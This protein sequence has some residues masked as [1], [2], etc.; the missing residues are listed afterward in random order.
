MIDD[1]VIEDAL[2]RATSE[3]DHIDYTVEV[4]DKEKNKDWG[5]GS[6]CLRNSI[7]FV[8]TAKVKNNP[9]DPSPKRAVKV[10]CNEVLQDIKYMISTD[11]TLD[12]NAYFVKYDSSER[13][14]LKSQ[15]VVRSA[16]QIVYIE[17]QYGQA[18][19]RPDVGAN[20]R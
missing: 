9:L 16:N 17:V 20:N 14:Y 6:N 7:F 3:Y 19:N 4:E 8:V 15:N 18:L 2:N 1:Q 10:K 11:T 5:L 12:G 13:K